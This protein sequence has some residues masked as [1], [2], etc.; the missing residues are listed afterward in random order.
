LLYQE[1]IERHGYGGRWLPMLKMEFEEND[2][3]VPS[4]LRK[5]AD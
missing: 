5:K 3:N 2:L 1:V 4:F